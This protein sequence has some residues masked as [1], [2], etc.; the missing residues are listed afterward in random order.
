MRS[1]EGGD[2]AYEEQD[3]QQGGSDVKRCLYSL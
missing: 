2:M 1:L 3:G